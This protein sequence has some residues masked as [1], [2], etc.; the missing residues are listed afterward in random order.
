MPEYLAMAGVND[1]KNGTFDDGLGTLDDTFQTESNSG[2]KIEEME[3]LTMKAR[4][5]D[6]RNQNVDQFLT[7]DG[8]NW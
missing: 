7:D 8:R 2:T 3:Y 5:L 1:D 4:I 6:D